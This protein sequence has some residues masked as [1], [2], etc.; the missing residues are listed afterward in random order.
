MGE[1]VQTISSIVLAMCAVVAVG[2]MRCT[3]RNER[4]ANKA[5]KPVGDWLDLVEN[6]RHIGAVNSRITIGEFGDFECPACGG[7]HRSTLQPFLTD[8]P[9]SATLIL[10]H[11]PLSYHRFAYPAARASECAAEQDRFA[12][13]HNILY[14]KQDSLGLITFRELAATVGIHDLDAFD[15]CNARTG[16]VPRVEVDMTEATARGGTGTPT[17]FVNGYRHFEMPSRQQLDSI[18][19]A[20][21]SGAS[22]G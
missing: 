13:Y 19:E 6:G 14:D 8:H 18:L 1:R 3:D 2:S 5:A 4:D 22:D 15:Q 17:I 7:Y 9:E 10:R 21:E 20:T 12:E 16:K 11:W